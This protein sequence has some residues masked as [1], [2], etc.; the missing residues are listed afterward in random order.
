VTGQ[1]QAELIERWRQRHAYPDAIGMWAN[2][3]GQEARSF[4]FNAIVQ[5]PRVLHRAARLQAVK[6]AAQAEDFALALTQAGT[7]AADTWLAAA[8]FVLQTI[9][10]WRK[11]LRAY[12]HRVEISAG[13]AGPPTIHTP[14][15]DPW[16]SAAHNF[17]HVD[18]ATGLLA[19]R[20]LHE[21]GTL[22][23]ER[24]QRPWDHVIALAVLRHAADRL[25]R[26][27][28]ADARCEAIA[29][30]RA[31]L[32]YAEGVGLAPFMVSHSGPGRPAHQALALANDAR[33]IRDVLGGTQAAAC[34]AAIDFHAF[35]VFA[36]DHRL[37]PELPLEEA[38]ELA[39][40]ALRQA[41][42]VLE[43]GG[44]GLP[45]LA[46]SAAAPEVVRLYATACLPDQPETNSEER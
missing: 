2:A 12:E 29:D 42:R 23:L 24:A 46:E 41:N 21:L 36:L 32:S 45:P 17:P 38:R 37:V 4:A 34:Q 16:Q 26:E 27:A 7:P 10:A 40:A 3:T 28:N 5:D 39:A 13:A 15:H 35:A 30:V 43:A 33:T 25:R 31:V 19:T 1:G 9:D 20:V 14:V 22:A 44:A 8:R 11:S 18:E 6:M